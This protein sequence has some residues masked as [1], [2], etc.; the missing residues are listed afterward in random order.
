MPFQIVL[1]DWEGQDPTVL[2]SKPYCVSEALK[3]WVPSEDAITCVHLKCESD[4]P[5]SSSPMGFVL[6]TDCDSGNKAK[7]S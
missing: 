3:K 6:I 2:Y 4:S 7:V 1:I 5:S